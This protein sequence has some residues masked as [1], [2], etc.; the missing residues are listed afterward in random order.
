[1]G[2]V[3][4]PSL[5]TK[6]LVATPISGGNFRIIPPNC[7]VKLGMYALIKLNFPFRKEKPLFGALLTAYQTERLVCPMYSLSQSLQGI[8]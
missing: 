7:M 2:G 4:I 5:Q 1:M 6:A 8:E 3:N